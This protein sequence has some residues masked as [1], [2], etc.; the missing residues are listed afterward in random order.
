[1]TPEELRM[2]YAKR[3]ISFSDY[4][5]QMPKL[6]PSKWSIIDKDRAKKLGIQ[7][8]NN[9]TLMMGYEV[10]PNNLNVDKAID[11]LIEEKIIEKL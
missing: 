7:L 2:K 10:L 6:P 9:G 4:V 5:R 8:L 1:M 3:E 11:W